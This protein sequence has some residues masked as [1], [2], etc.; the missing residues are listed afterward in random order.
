MIIMAFFTENILL[1]D[2]NCIKNMFVQL[3]Y[4]KN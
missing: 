2:I 3:E 4:E 1:K